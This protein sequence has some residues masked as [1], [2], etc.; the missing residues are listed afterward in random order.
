MCITFLCSLKNENEKSILKV[1]GCSTGIGWELFS[2][3]Q[4]LKINTDLRIKLAYYVKISRW[5]SQIK[6]LVAACATGKVLS[7]GSR[8][9]VR[10]RTF[11]LN[12]MYN[13]V[14]G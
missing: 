11:A 10:R 14:E 13:A 12:K 2:W 1:N 8:M 7:K 9:R 3:M 5:V 6:G 4:R